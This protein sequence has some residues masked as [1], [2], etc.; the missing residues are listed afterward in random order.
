[1]RI[2]TN[3]TEVELCMDVP[4]GVGLT[5]TRHGSRKRPHAFEVTLTGY[6]ARRKNRDDP[7]A[8]CGYDHPR[9]R[10]CPSSIDTDGRHYDKFGRAL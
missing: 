2:H 8:C 7:C 3:L 9:E 10:D 5:F 6:G 4:R 1:M